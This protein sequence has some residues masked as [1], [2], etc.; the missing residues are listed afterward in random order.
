MQEAKEMTE[1]YEK[2]VNVREDTMIKGKYTVYEF[3]LTK[4]KEHRI[5]TLDSNTATIIREYTF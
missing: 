4:G 1:R 3:D 5:T 2:L